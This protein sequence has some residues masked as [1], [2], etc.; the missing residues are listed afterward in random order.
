[1][2]LVDLACW[3]ERL[4]HSRGLG[5]AK[6]QAQEQEA[7]NHKQNTM[8]LAIPST[9]WVIKKKLHA[10]QCGGGC[11]HWRWRW[12][13]VR[14]RSGCIH[15]ASGGDDGIIWSVTGVITE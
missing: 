1:M 3:R 14:S 2:R 11:G 4:S 12:P 9:R 15:P 10:H 7:A 8:R 6:G 13:R 5:S